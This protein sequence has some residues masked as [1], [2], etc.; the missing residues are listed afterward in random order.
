MT[1]LKHRTPV[2]DSGKGP[3]TMDPI[4]TYQRI[5]ESSNISTID[6]DV[7]DRHRPSPTEGEIGHR[8]SKRYDG[9]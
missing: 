8:Q 3:S 2:P 1:D 6:P 4:C 7:G 9:P 5:G